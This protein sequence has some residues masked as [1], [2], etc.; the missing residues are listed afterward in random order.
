MKR[1]PKLAEQKMGQAVPQI[2]KRFKTRVKVIT[3]IKLTKT[4]P[5]KKM[6]HLLLQ[7]LITLRHPKLRKLNLMRKMIMFLTLQD[8]WVKF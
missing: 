5:L 3:V 4:R 6:L 7:W 8:H 2:P 1:T